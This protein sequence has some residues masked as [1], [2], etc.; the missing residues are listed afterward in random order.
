MLSLGINDGNDLVIE[1]EYGLPNR[2]PR[3][4]LCETI[5]RKFYLFLMTN[6]NIIKIALQ[7]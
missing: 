7:L 5:N 6:Y 2:S 4:K 3:F 1:R